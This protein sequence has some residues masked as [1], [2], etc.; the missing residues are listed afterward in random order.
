MLDRSYLHRGILGMSRYPGGGVEGWFPIHYAAAVLAAHRL[1]EDP[2]YAPAVA[3]MQAQVDLM[4]ATHA[5]LFQGAPAGRLD[6]DAI[7]RIARCIEERIHRH[8]HS[9]HSV[10]F[11]AHAMRALTA[12]P[13]CG[14]V[15]VVEGICQVIGYFNRNQGVGL[16]PAA[17][18]AFPDFSPQGVAD[19]VSAELRR[20]PDVVP[21]SIGHIGLGH[22]MTHGHALI[23]LS[24]LG[25]VHLAE[26]GYGAF[27]A[28]LGGARAA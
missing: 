7:G 11:A 16:D 19:L 20:I 8:S 27:C 24:R 25:H 12:A 28:H 15:E 22:V 26:K 9:G 23:E 6:P 4:M 18:G 10:I 21:I 5:H 1:S 2:A 13:E 3:A 17:V 14:R